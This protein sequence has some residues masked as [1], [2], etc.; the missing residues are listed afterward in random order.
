MSKR[1][2][3]SASEK[4]HIVKVTPVKQENWHK[5]NDEY[6]FYMLCTQNELKTVLKILYDG[7]KIS[8]ASDAVYTTEEHDFVDLREKYEQKAKKQKTS[9]VDEVDA[10]DGDPQYYDIL[11]KTPK[12]ENGFYAK[13]YYC[14]GSYW[15]VLLYIDDLIKENPTY[16]KCMERPLDLRSPKDIRDFI[17][18]NNKYEG[19]KFRTRRQ[20]IEGKSFNSKDYYYL[21]DYYRIN[22]DR[23]NDY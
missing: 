1:K 12:Q 22:N 10:V 9:T 23:N 18:Q 16:S 6:G 21:G 15:Q 14:Y 8:Q 20:F 17:Y 4:Q 7:C 5:M 11:L 3:Q 2:E 13:S 19:D